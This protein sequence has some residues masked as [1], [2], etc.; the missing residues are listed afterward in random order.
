MTCQELDNE[1]VNLTTPYGV[2]G[3]T[4][5]VMCLYGVSRWD[6]WIEEEAALCT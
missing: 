5:G 6:Y 2:A 1:G 3:Y 4:R